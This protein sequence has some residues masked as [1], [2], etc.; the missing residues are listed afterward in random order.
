MSNEDKRKKEKIVPDTSI[1]INGTL[2]ALLERDGIK[3]VEIIIPEFVIDELQAQA[4]KGLVIGFKGLEEIKKI[5]S[6]SKEKNIKIKSAGRRQTLEEIKLA[7]SGRIDALIIDVAL[8]NNAVLYTSDIVQAIVAESRGAEA[9]YFKPYEKKEKLK[10]EKLFTENTLSIHLKEGVPPLAKIGKP[11]N[12]RL[13][14]LRKEPM[15]SEEIEEIIS[16]IMSAAKYESGFIE[17]NERE[18]TVIQLENLRIAISRPPFS[19]GTE[20]TVV[21]PII[22]LTLDDYK[23]SEKLKE[24]IK[25]G[26]G[27]I[28]AG[29]PGSGKSTLAASI[30]E[31]YESLGRIVKTMEQ[32]RD[33]QVNEKITQYSKLKGDFEKTA[34]FILLVRPDYTIFDEIRTTKDFLIFKDLR[35]AGIGMIG[36]LHANS[37]I[38]AIQRFIDRIDLGMLSHVI[39]TIIFV[40]FGEIK[41]VYSLSLVVRTPTG[42]QDPDLARPIVEVRDFLTNELEYEIYSFGEEKVIFSVKRE[43]SPIELLAKERIKKEISVFDKNPEIEIYGNRAIIKV[44][45]KVIPKIIGKDGETIKKIEKRLGIS[46][47]IIPKIVTMKKEVDFSFE[48]SG[49]YFV[50][51][52]DKSL[53]NHKINFYSDKEFIISVIVGKN[54]IVKIRKDSEEGKKIAASV[55]KGSIK[56]FV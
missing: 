51:K 31:F 46:I 18:A 4:S 32:P 55:L 30:A 12:F 28:I 37:P 54:G 14:E 45:N 39:D 23:L 25:T 20:I 19:D 48:E 13:T 15:T 7:R 6:L 24:R 5:R 41:K 38:D 10:I 16:E 53:Y 44:D 34:D 36:V 9:K 42:M 47:D 40:K 8:E 29:P 56:V 2:S 11:G 17:V 49:N 27:I 21:K 52:F 22:K 35:L 50:F 26:E 3:N 1:L 43:E 33:L